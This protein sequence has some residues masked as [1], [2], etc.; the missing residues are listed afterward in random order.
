MKRQPTACPHPL[1]AVC[2]GKKV[3]RQRVAIDA[4]L[5]AV[6]GLVKK[7]PVPEQRQVRAIGRGRPTKGP[8]DAFY[9]G[10]IQRV[11]THLNFPNPSCVIHLHS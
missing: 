7:G 6:D 3:P 2:L 9:M 5:L 4:Q 11:M 8:T 10:V 1:A